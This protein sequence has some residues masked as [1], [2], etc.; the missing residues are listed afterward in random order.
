[1]G[2]GSWVLTKWLQA[3]IPR[4]DFSHCTVFPSEK[5]LQNTWGCL[6]GRAG[7]LV[8]G[9]WSLP[10]ISSRLQAQWVWPRREVVQ[11]NKQGTSEFLRSC[12]DIVAHSPSTGCERSCGVLGGGELGESRSTCARCH[13]G[14]GYAALGC[15]GWGLDPGL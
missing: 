2:V 4:R 13:A 9:V 1:M 11:L 12:G 6:R 15:P 14:L 10:S 7:A 8:F 3:V 5:H